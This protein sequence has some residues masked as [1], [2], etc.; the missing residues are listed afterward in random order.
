MKALAQVRRSRKALDVPTEVLPK[1]D[2]RAARIG[3]IFLGHPCVL[4]GHAKALLD[5]RVGPFRPALEEISGLIEDPRLPEGSAGDHDPGATGL[6]AHAHG[7]LGRLD[8]SIPEYRNTQGVDHRRDLVPAGGPGVHLRAGAGVERK[9]PHAGILAAPCDRDRVT[10]LLIPPTANLAR[11][12]QVRTLNDA[13]NDVL[14]KPQVAKTAR[15]TVAPNDF[16]DGATEVDVD[17]FRSEHV[18]DQSSGLAHRD[19]IGAKDLHA[20]RSLVGVKTKF[21]D[22]SW[23]LAANPFGGQKL[24]DNNVSAEAAAE[25]SEQRLRDASH[26]REE[27][28]H[29]GGEGQRKAFP[30]V[31]LRS[32]RSL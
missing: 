18:G 24:R 8:V 6:P 20:D 12:R 29:L 13:T 2:R 9:D 3:L 28:G 15:T 22:R 25:S 1:L 11:H 27:E 16:L 19:G 32:G 4:Q 10:H 23:I 31:K 7:V 26:R 30:S 5:P 21:V 17:E 14:N